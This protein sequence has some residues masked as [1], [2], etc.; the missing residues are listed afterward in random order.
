MILLIGMFD[1][2]DLAQGRIFLLNLC[3]CFDQL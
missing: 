1:G 2:R 3:D